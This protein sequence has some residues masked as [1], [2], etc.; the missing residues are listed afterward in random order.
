MASNLVAQ[1]GTLRF[2]TLRDHVGATESVH[3]DVYFIGFPAEL[4]ADLQA[5]VNKTLT[6]LAIEDR[7]RPRLGGVFDTLKNP[8]HAWTRVHQE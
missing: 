7:R 6:G 5:G 1:Q 8:A 4:Q 3:L 2:V